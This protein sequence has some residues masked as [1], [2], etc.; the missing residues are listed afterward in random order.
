MEKR[1]TLV[2]CPDT[3]AAVHAATTPPQ[4][5]SFFASGNNAPP[6]C[7]G[8][9]PRPLDAAAVSNAHRPRRAGDAKLTPEHALCVDAEAAADARRDAQRLRVSV[10]GVEHECQHLLRPGSRC[11]CRCNAMTQCRRHPDSSSC[12]K[13]HR[14]PSWRGN[15]QDHRSWRRPIKCTQLPLW[16]CSKLEIR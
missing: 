9:A 16:H 14:G 2:R 8:G 5:E 1:N 3:G 6:M 4:A 12:Q 15:H 10:D 13:V 7:P 11:S